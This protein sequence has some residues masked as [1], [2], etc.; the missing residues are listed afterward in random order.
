[1]LARL[2][3]PQPPSHA[4]SPVAAN[5]VGTVGSSAS[6]ISS[7]QLTPSSGA[8]HMPPLQAS[9]RV[10][11]RFKAAVLKTIAE[12][13]PTFEG[14]RISHRSGAFVSGLSPV[15]LGGVAEWLKAPVLKTGRGE[16][17]SRV[18]IPPPPP[19][20]TGKPLTCRII[21]AVLSGS[22]HRVPHPPTL[23]RDPSSALNGEQA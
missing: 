9:G 16:S 13:I 18:R 14:K 6:D 15:R 22:P 21:Y 1:M 17:L 2:R 4:A 10:A 11:E 7:V 12:G 23:F 19:I 8:P 20:T 3:R 5:P